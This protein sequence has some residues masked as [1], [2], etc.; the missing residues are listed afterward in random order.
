M[1]LRDLV[2]SGF[3]ARQAK[4]ILASA[5]TSYVTGTVI[6]GPFRLV[7]ADI[8]VGFAS[9]APVPA[10][11][12]LPSDGDVL[13][14]VW[15][16]RVV[17]PVLNPVISDLSAWPSLSVT[18]RADNNVYADFRLGQQ[19]LNTMLVGVMDGTAPQFSISDASAAY[20]AG[21]VDVYFLVAPI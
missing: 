5:G 10:V 8:P 3:T 17:E 13:L 2:R 21:E 14:S 1:N 6:E 7:L 15:Y 12:Y 20:T 16:R 4:G 11:T 18:A 19:Y 9:A